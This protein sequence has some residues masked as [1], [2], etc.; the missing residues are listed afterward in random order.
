VKRPYK[1]NRDGLSH[2]LFTNLENCPKY[3]MQLMKYKSGVKQFVNLEQEGNP[4]TPQINV[5]KQY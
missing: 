1:Q 5:Y 3:A 2:K 4:S